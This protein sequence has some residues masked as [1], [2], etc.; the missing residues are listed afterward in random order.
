MTMRIS[1]IH[2][3]DSITFGQYL[4]P[5][6][7]W[8]TIVSNCNRKVFAGLDLE[9][10]ARTYG[11][12][13]ETTRMG[14]ERFPQDVQDYTP[15]ILT[16]QY[17]LNDCNCW[18]TDKGHPRVS[19]AAFEANLLEMIART[20]VFGAKEIILSTNHRTLRRD[21]LASGEVYEDA[22]ARYCD[23]VREVA[24]QAEV[25]LC[26]IQMT[27][28]GFSDEQLARMV[29]P[30]PDLLHLS[31]EGNRVYA[32]TIYPYIRQ[33]IESLAGINSSTRE[34]VT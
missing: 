7:R 22:N 28:D 4:D 9:I 21:T 20:R 32:D 19:E 23:I 31:E 33:S 15:D 11:V 1:L 27:F 29:M 14:L 17:G 25:M 3:G 13:G 10:V 2:M 34:A 8:T 16:L 5:S 6:L 18:A 24:R 26:D 12:S 30:T